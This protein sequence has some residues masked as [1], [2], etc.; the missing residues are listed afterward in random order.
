MK[1]KAEI[2]KTDFLPDDILEKFN[3]DRKNVLFFVKCDMSSFDKFGESYCLATNDGVCVIKDSGEFLFKE[4]RVI[5][6][7]FAQTYVSAGSI[8]IG[9]LQ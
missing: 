9:L 8:V 7:I 2:E 4:Y 6:D 5:E 3:I 1:K